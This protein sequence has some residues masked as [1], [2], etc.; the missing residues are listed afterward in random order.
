MPNIKYLEKA[1]LFNVSFFGAVTANTPELELYVRAAIINFGEFL[2]HEV[3]VRGQSNEYY[4]QLYIKKSPQLSLDWF[5]YCAPK[6]VD[7]INFINKQKEKHL[8]LEN[9]I[10]TAW[11]S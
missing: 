1:K 6:L 4:I 9:I 8:C 3:P 5:K 7:L 11:K 10:H 2:D